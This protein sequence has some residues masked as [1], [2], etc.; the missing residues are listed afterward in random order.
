MSISPVRRDF[1][2]MRPMTRNVVAAPV[3]SLSSMTHLQ[4]WQA[5]A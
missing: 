1:P 2:E 4:F 5:G 3:S